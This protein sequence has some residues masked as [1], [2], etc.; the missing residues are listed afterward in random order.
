MT[1]FCFSRVNVL[2]SLSKEN[3]LLGQAQIV[4]EKLR[5]FSIRE[6]ELK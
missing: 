1:N 5:V 3:V 2:I 6:A 4:C